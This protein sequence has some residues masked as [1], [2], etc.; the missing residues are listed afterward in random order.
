[1]KRLLDF[2]PEHKVLLVT[3]SESL[4]EPEYLAVREDVQRFLQIEGPCHVILD[5]RGISN[6]D[7]SAD[8]VRM[9]AEKPPTFPASKIRVGVASQPVIY[10]MLR[11][12]E[13]IGDKTR[14]QL[15]VVR[16]MEEAHSL[17]GFQSLAFPRHVC[18]PNSCV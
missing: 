15:H 9:L 11:M 7:A 5:F 13:I 8:F 4:T 6:F 14:Q 17:L 16:T 12:F 18:G 1:M 3:L 2:D 10:G